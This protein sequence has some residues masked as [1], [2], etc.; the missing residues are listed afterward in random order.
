[1]ERSRLFGIVKAS[2]HFTTMERYTY[3][4]ETRSQKSMMWLAG[5]QKL[6]SLESTVSFTILIQ[7]LQGLC[8]GHPSLIK[9]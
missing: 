2:C 3:S 7:Y 5:L 6:S 4:T 1:M 9:V 8:E